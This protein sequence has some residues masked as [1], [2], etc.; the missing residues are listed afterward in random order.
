MALSAANAGEH[1]CGHEH[2]FVALAALFR[3]LP[4]VG[5]SPFG[6][7]AVVAG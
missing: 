4:T 5:F 2:G 7:F 1:H 3:E 6:D